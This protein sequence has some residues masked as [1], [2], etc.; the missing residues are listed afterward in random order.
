[1]FILS[2]ILPHKKNEIQMLWCFCQKNGFYEKYVDFVIFP[3]YFSKIN[4]VMVLRILIFRHIRS[5]LY[6]TVL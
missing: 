3:V 6:Y 1:M 4:F 5:K 2:S